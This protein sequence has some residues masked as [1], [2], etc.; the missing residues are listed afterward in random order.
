MSFDLKFPL[1][2]SVGVD[3]SGLGET[4]EFDINF[5]LP[6]SGLWIRVD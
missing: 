5:L 1:P 2:M 3:L 6:G 4:V